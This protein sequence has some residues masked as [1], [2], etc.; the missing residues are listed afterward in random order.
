MNARTPLF[1]TIIAA[2]ILFMR[3]DLLLMGVGASGRQTGSNVVVE[4]GMCT[5]LDRLRLFI[6]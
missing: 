4:S 1:A 2:G 6:S 3:K 5:A